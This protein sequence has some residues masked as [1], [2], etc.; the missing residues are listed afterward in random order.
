VGR[1][2]GQG[3]GREARHLPPLHPFPFGAPGAEP[4]TSALPPSPTG[5]VMHSALFVHLDQNPKDERVNHPAD[6]GRKH[7]L[8]LIFN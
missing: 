1:G 2:L 6:R 5:D 3:R 7:I 8:P 4:N